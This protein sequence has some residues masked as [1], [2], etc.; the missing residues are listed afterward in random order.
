MRNDR[1]FFLDGLRGLAAVL[2][3]LYHFTQH[4]ADP[5]MRNAYFA[6]DLFFVLSGFVIAKSYLERVRN[7]MAFTHFL[8]LRLARL[9]PMYA[10]SLILGLGA[11]LLAH[12]TGQT[13]YSLVQIASA[14]VTNA[15]YLPTFTPGVTR[16]AEGAVRNA[17][18]PL[19][20][21]AWTL[22]FELAVNLL[23]FHLWRLRLYGPVLLGFVTATAGLVFVSVVID[24]GGGDGW[25]FTDGHLLKGAYRTLY[26]FSA[27]VAI[28]ALPAPR[29]GRFLQIVLGALILSAFVGICMLD[30]EWPGFLLAILIAP[31]MVYLGS[32]IRLE[33]SGARIAE[34]LGGLSYPLY[35]IHYPILTLASASGMIAMSGTV[36]PLLWLGFSVTLSAAAARYFDLPLRQA[37]RRRL[38]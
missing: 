9:Y 12:A 18:F 29:I 10:G 34:W 3:A 36:V 21:P 1:Y 35:C 24:G 23:F 38:S 25:S 14:F 30:G 31:F 4:T 27:G 6:V 13:S 19:N 7:G 5:M 32:G 33:A 28:A 2:V 37:L 17:S 16:I 11:L 20:N 26:G 8:K 15:A 22:F